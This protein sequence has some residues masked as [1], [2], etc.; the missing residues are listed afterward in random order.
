M[1]HDGLGPHSSLLQPLASSSND[2]QVR[3]CRDMETWGSV[4][5]WLMVGV[6]LMSVLV[7][8]VAVWRSIVDG[9]RTSLDVQAVTDEARRANA[10]ASQAQAAASLSA[11]AAERS[12]DAAEA[13]EQR[14]RLA[15]SRSVE[16]H[17][18]SWKFDRLQNEHSLKNLGP[19]DATDVT[20]T[21]LGLGIESVELNF[22]TVHAK[23]TVKIP[24]PES[25]LLTQAVARVRWFSPLGVPRISG[26]LHAPGRTWV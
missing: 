19:N 10:I 3:Y 24:L 17:E 25:W 26:E 18:V 11:K 8:I 12:A 16:V 14:Q 20:V 13:A 21:V 23:E 1:L 4:T 6:T 9:K 15:E 5:D 2:I 7:A 22:P